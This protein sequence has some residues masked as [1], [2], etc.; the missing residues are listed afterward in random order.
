MQ[1][2]SVVHM[3][4]PQADLSEP[5]KDLRLGEEPPAL[6][7]DHFLEISSVRVVHNDAQLALLSLIDLAE[8][9]NIGMIEN[10]Q[11]FSLLQSVLPL[12]LAHLS[13][14]DLLDDGELLGTLALHQER[15]TEGSLT[16]QLDLLVDLEGFLLLGLLMLGG[17]GCRNLLLHFAYS[18]LIIMNLT[19]SL[20]KLTPP[21]R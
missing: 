19:T 15:F 5:I 3:L 18:N 14:V 6:L 13:N 4:E 1:N 16:E 11:D 17:G 10:L 12:I 7:L 2:L 9:N 20:S 8:T 21:Q